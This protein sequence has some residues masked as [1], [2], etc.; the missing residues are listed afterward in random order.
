MI[1]LIIVQ[2]ISY[3]PTVV[4]VYIHIHTFTCTDIFCTYN[5]VPYKDVLVNDG[6]YIGWSPTW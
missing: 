4:Y 6:L 1:I 2:F 3:K 5:P